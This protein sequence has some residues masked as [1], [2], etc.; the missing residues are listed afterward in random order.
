[1]FDFICP[2]VLHG[3][4]LRFAGPHCTA[5][6][7]KLQSACAVVEPCRPPPVLH[8]TKKNT[9]KYKW[10]ELADSMGTVFVV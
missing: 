5:R 8:K 10:F 7:K 2:L 1:M 6:V 9:E 3:S 4:R